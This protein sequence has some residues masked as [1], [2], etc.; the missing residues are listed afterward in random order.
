MEKEVTVTLKVTGGITPEQIREWL[1][2]KIEIDR[3]YDD[4]VSENI[5]ITEVR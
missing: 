3:Q 2:V 4:E 5:E 1:S